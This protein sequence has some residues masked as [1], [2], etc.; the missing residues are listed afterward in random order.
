MASAEL[1]G[2]LRARL[3]AEEQHI[4][5]LRVAGRSWA[6]VAREL[7]GSA[8]ARRVQFQRAISRVGRELGLEVV[9][10]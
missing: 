1:L 6:E 4:A 7:G 10:E 8:D 5:D 2:A 9:D 3:S